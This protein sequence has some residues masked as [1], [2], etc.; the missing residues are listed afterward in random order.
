[1][2]PKELIPLFIFVPFFLLA[3]FAIDEYFERKRIK[4]DL[5]MIQRDCPDYIKDKL[6]KPLK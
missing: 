2:N 1:M 6:N 5:E 4:R 3:M